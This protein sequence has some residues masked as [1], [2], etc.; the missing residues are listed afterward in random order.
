VI[1]ACNTASARA[2][3]TLQQRHLPARRPDRRILGVVRPSAEALAGLPPEAVPGAAPA[4]DS[5]GTVAV[6]G[7]AGTVASDSYHLELEKLAPRLRLI[8]QACPLWVPLVEEG[9][10]SGPGTD[11]F[12]HKYLDP[13]LAAAPDLTRILLGCTHY[14][15][16]LPAIRTVVPPAIELIEQGEIVALRLSQWMARHPDMEA[17][18]GR[19]GA[20]RYL[21]TDDPAWFAARAATLLGRDIAAEPARLRAV[22]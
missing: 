15:L 18:L 6:L 17:R 2:L 22:D 3:R 10:L 4:V 7:T 5:T 12:L 14:P 9:E 11:F 13:V 20:R 19:G 16:L 21:T 8:Q 1:L